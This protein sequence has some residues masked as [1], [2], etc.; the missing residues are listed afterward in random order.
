MGLHQQQMR[1]FPKGFD[2]DGGQGRDD[3]PAGF[4][5]GQMLPCHQLQRT[6]PHLP[7][8]LLFEDHPVLIPA[9]QQFGPAQVVHVC[10]RN[11]DLGLGIHSGDVTLECRD[12]HADRIVQLERVWPGEEQVWKGVGDAPD[13]SAQVA[14]GLRFAAPWPQQAGQETAVAASQK[15]HTGDEPLLTGGY[16]HCGAAAA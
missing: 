15:S 1:R 11:P 12:V 2:A 13:G 5:C 16:R 7:D 8:P 4:T 10:V 14:R 6:Q 9:R 3:G